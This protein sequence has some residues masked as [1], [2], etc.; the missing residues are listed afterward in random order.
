MKKKVKE[1]QKDNK[2]KSKEVKYL[3]R[4]LELYRVE[5]RRDEAQT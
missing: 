3:E 1:L 2:A 4:I 5:E